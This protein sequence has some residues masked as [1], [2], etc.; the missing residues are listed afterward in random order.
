[1]K[2][3]SLEIEGLKVIELKVWRDARGF[4]TERFQEQ[5]FKE[6]G[7]PTRFSQDNHSRSLPKVLRGLHFQLNPDQGKLVGALRGKIWDI[8]IDIRPQSKTFGKHFSL[9]LSDENGL[10][11]WIPGGFAH[12][13]CVL[14]EEPADVLY[15]V[16]IPYDPKTE[17]G[18]L[19]SDPDL[20]IQ[21][22]VKDPIISERDQQLPS[23]KNFREK[24]GDFSR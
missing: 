5:K 13:F 1:M 17:G 22:P 10:L 2:I 7:L 21:W 3:H 16:D 12:G 4:F 24:I 18:I 8:A 19:W 11:I 6:A 15:K 20:H 9:E 23:F 14:G